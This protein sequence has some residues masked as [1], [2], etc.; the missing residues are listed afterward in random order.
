MSSCTPEGRKWIFNSLYLNI[1]YSRPRDSM[2][3]LGR[4][5]CVCEGGGWG[6]GCMGE[7]VMAFRVKNYEILGVFI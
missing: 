4:D 3:S 7:S 6:R 1:C 2:E 5:F